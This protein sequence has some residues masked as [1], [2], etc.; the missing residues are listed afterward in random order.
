MPV[1]RP[2]GHRRRSAPA[3]ARPVR[4]TAGV[5]A[6][7][8]TAAFA[9]ALVV[10]G[11]TGAA[12]GTV[13]AARF[14]GPAGSAPAFPGAPLSPTPAPTPT[15]SLSPPPTG[16]PSPSPAPTPSRSPTPTP[17]PTPTRSPSPSPSP[18]GSPSPSPTGSPSPSPSP[19]SG[20]PSPAP[21]ASAGTQNGTQNG[22][23]G[24]V[25]LGHPPVLPLGT[26]P[27]R[28]QEGTRGS[29]GHLFPA[30]T[31]SPAAAP[32]ARRGFASRQTTSFIVGGRL[33][34]RNVS[35]FIVLAVG[36]GA[37]IAGTAAW[38]S[39]GRLRSRLRL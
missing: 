35:G 9:C 15:F 29:I 26:V 27:P 11:G 3:R 7:G 23:L 17:S 12:A 19:G 21:S 5:L 36:F 28:V 6:G 10:L 8:V 38:L 32:S 39:L 13:A 37:A 25:P 33:A 14:A 30:V 31:P 24:V 2:D 20:S 1:I 34:G 18:T 16:S 4:A 22:A